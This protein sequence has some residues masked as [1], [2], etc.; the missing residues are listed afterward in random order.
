MMED[1]VKNREGKLKLFLR[2]AWILAIIIA[3]SRQ[4]FAEEDGN[5][6]FFE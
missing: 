3:F 4:G 2:V 1:T 5:S 6:R